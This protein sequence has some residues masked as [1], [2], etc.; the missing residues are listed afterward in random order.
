MKLFQSL[1][2]VGS[3]GQEAHDLGNDGHGSDVPFGRVVTGG[4]DSDERENTGK[5]Q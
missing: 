1:L 4:L 2:I 3:Y 5:S